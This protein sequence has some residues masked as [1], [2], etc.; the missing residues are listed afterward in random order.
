MLDVLALA[1]ATCVDVVIRIEPDFLAEPACIVDHSGFDSN[2][3]YQACFLACLSTQSDQAKTGEDGVT[4][5]MDLT[6][7]AS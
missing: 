6:N 3:E 2:A 5:T 4:Y 7:K 1:L